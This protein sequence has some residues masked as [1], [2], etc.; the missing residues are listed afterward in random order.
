[1][2]WIKRNTLNTVKDIVLENTKME[3]NDLIYDNREF[4]YPGLDKAAKLFIS[5][6]KKNSVIRVYGDYDVDGVTS[7]YILSSLFK[8]INYKNFKLVSPHRFTDGYGI[9]VNR[10]REFYADG[11]NLLITIDNGIAALDA[12]KLAKDLSMDVLILDHHEPFI[13]EANEVVLPEADV[14]VDPHVTGGYL[15]G[16][17]NHSFDDLCGAG[18]GYKFA[19]EVLSHL[20]SLKEDKKEEILQK[21]L[22]AAAVGTV[23]DVV[24]LIDDNRKIVK[25][26]LK[27]IASGKASTGLR[28]LVK[29]MNVNK[30]DSEALAFSIAPCI[31]ASGRLYDD[32]AE[33]MVEILTF[34]GKINDEWI[35]TAASKA[36][37]TNDERKA[38]TLEAVNRAE[39]IMASHLNDNVIVL[40]DD[41]LT[42]GIAGL[43]SSK[44]TEEFYRPSIVLTKTGLFL[45]GSGRSVDGTDLKALLDATQEYLAGYGGHPMAA[46]VSL[47]EE[48]LDAFRKA[49][50][51]IAPKPVPTTD[52]YYDIECEPDKD[53]LRGT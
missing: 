51:L 4:V 25:E 41:K 40:L 14:I 31:N 53:S 2:A 49:I 36:K 9:N 12:I 13:N 17:E 18:L 47:K 7:L 43:V 22:S 30:L 5:H 8:A 21:M 34:D 3:L 45:K 15:L 42:S 6:V 48:N 10:V 16:D 38:L 28:A 24:T 52:I 35:E 27:L 33:T 37:E 50:C 32:G 19:S 11:C 44:L 29:V 1:M 46:G 20:K 23:A 26:G 39:D